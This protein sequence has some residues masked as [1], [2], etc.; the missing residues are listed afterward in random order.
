MTLLRNLFFL[1]SITI[2][3]LASTILAIFNYNPYE[4]TPL[5]MANFYASFLVSIA[6]VLSIILYYFKIK[7]SKNETIFGFLWPSIRQATF[8]A[9]A[10]TTLLYLRG[11]GI[12]DWLTGTSVIVVSILLELFFES[13]KNNIKAN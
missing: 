11:L 4:A 1:L 7:L 9:I 8:I 6:G 5:A 12:L 3:A 10:L 13:K 2:F